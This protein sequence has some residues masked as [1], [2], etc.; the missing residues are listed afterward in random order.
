MQA[1][2]IYRRV[3]PSNFSQDLKILSRKNMTE[4]PGKA[5]FIVYRSGVTLKVS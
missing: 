4:D 3:S 5:G 1:S 2:R